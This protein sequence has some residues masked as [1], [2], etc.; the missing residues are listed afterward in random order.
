MN[1]TRSLPVIMPKVS[2]QQWSCHSCGD[3][4]RT[5]VGH[6]FDDEQERI[7]QQGWLEKLGVAPMVRLGRQWVL[8]KRADGTC[9]FL[10]E[11]NRC[12]IH[13]EYG[14]DA[15]PLACRIFPFSV[16][17][18]RNG[19]QASLRFDCPSVV[20]SKGQPLRQHRAWLAKLVERLDHQSPAEHDTADLQKRRPATVEEIDVVVSRFTRWLRSDVGSLSDRLI[21]AARITAALSGARL[22]SVRGPQF[23]ELVDLLFA[24]PLEDFAVSSP[25]ATRRQRGMLRQ[26]VFAHAEFV[27]LEERKSSFVRKLLKRWDQLRGGR[28]FRR[29]R[30]IVGKPDGLPGGITFDDVESVEPPAADHEQIDNLA[31]RYLIARIEGRSVFGDGYYGWQVFAGLTALWLSVAAAGWLARQS[32]AIDG[33]R[34]LTFADVGSALGIVDRAATRVPALGSIAERARVVYLLREDGIAR[35]LDAFSFLPESSLANPVEPT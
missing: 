33:R 15:K 21:A 30:G 24:S 34:A 19:W 4:C 20:Q 28:R 14:E 13:A 1:R 26:L 3:C 5:L 11:D 6:L 18:V 25:P 2:G 17:P 7:K 22:A 8:N 31:L 9:V 10:S 32:A 12:R 29:G 23:T 35:L 16:R 27:T